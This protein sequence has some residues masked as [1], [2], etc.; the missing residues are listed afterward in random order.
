M[1]SFIQISQEWLVL[2]APIGYQGKWSHKWV[3]ESSELVMLK[4]AV[5]K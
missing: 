1:E 5:G 3:V 2:T 4:S